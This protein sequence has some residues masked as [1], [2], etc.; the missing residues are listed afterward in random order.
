MRQRILAYVATAV[1]V[2][3]LLIGSAQTAGSA[4]QKVGMCH[5]A[6]MQQWVY[7]RV[8]ED[9]VRS[10]LAHGD[11]LGANQAECAGLSATR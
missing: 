6:D 10:H 1:S 11:F 4:P 7:I 3:F 8:E 2:A 5:T 9:A